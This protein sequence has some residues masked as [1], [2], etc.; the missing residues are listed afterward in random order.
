[1]PDLPPY[2]S[3]RRAAFL[4]GQ[5]EKVIARRRADGSLPPRGPYAAVGREDLELVM[6]RTLS[7][8]DWDRSTVEI[9]RA[10][11]AKRE[12]EAA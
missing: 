10:G 6:G 5:S 4:S 11:M 8:A 7:A 2:F 1:M 3:A 12:V 9:N